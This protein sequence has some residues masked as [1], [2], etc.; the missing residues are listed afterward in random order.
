MT[1]AD[2]REHLLMSDGLRTVR[3]DV[4]AGTLSSGPTELHYRLAG[5]GSAERPLL[6]LRRFLALW[7]TAG[8]CRRSPRGPLDADASCP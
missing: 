3:L 6:T 1:A 4:L 5:L 7:H 2:G 8:F